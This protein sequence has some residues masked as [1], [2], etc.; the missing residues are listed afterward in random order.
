MSW[1][2]S[3]SSA[4]KTLRLSPWTIRFILRAPAPNTNVTLVVAARPWIFF[5]GSVF[6][7]PHSLKYL[8]YARLSHRGRVRHRNEDACAASPESGV[9]VVCDGMGGAAAGEVASN[10]A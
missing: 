6:G 2:D 10:L 3:A 4:A 9:F 8:I 1:V 7:S 5:F